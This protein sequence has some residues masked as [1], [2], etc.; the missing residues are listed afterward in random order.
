MTWGGLQWA[1]PRAVSGWFLVLYWGTVLAL[2]VASLLVAVWDI[3][4]VRARFA[5]E[6]RNAFHET[7]G[8]EGLRRSIRDAHAR[9]R[10]GDR[11]RMN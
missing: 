5:L 4:Y 3:L 11:A 7:L 6:Q 1:H 8:E 10:K 9:N 2:L